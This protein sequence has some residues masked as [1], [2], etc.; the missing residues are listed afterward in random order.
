MR[1]D[2]EWERRS[3][4]AAQRAVRGAYKGGKSRKPKEEEED[5]SCPYCGGDGR[6]GGC[7]VCGARTAWRRT[8]NPKRKFTKQRVSGWGV[9]STDIREDE[10]E[11]RQA[12]VDYHSS[13]DRAVHEWAST[14]LQEAGI[15]PQ[16]RWKPQEKGYSTHRSYS[17]PADADLGAWAGEVIDHIGDWAQDQGFEVET[18]DDDVGLAIW[19]SG[20][21]FYSVKVRGADG[22]LQ[23]AVV[24]VLPD[25]EANWERADFFVE[26]PSGE[27][28]PGLVRGKP[29]SMAITGNYMKKVRAGIRAAVQRNTKH[30]FGGNKKLYR[31][32]RGPTR[33]PPGKMTT[34]TLTKPE[35]RK[36]LA[37]ASSTIH[38]QKK[39]WGRLF[40]GTDTRI[41]DADGHVL[42]I[43]MG[44]VI[45]KLYA[46]GLASKLHDEAI[47][48]KGVY[49]QGL[50]HAEQQ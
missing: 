26:L 42:A 1:Y 2:E 14:L 10:T 33:N 29:R 12:W 15:S 9:P 27:A 5:G 3:R 8:R 32:G 28:A 7:K 36:I 47:W 30:F 24:Q 20:K 23:T 22:E 18:I 19:V 17:I 11:L 6:P 21:T 13:K 35:T 4:E 39:R 50:A 41:I 38:E 44:P 49:L 31:N 45:S 37:M 34:I 43:H 48:S 16:Q 40:G 25:S 46:D